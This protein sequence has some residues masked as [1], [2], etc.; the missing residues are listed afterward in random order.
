[1]NKNKKQIYDLINILLDPQPD[2][3]GGRSDAAMDLGDIEDLEVFNALMLLCKKP[4]L[5]AI[6]DLVLADAGESLG[7]IINK[8]I[9]ADKNSSFYLAFDPSI[10][11]CIHKQA[12]LE[13]LSCLEPALVQQVYNYAITEGHSN[14]TIL[15]YW[16][17]K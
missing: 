4:D 16:K 15:Q 1:M 7:N 2:Y 14:T 13:L 5:D 6:N 12:M 10:L 9:Q 17:Q 8:R 11:D 3:D